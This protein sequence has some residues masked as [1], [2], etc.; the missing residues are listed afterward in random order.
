MK[1]LN[2]KMKSERKGKVEERKDTR[3]N[4]LTNEVL[5]AAAKSVV[6]TSHE[7]LTSPSLFVDEKIFLV[8][9]LQTVT[10]FFLFS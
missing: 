7:S 4:V 9:D 3:T 2:R 8:T 6:V 10:S 1:K 5:C